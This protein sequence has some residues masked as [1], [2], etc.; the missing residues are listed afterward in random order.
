MTIIRQPLRR[1]GIKW[2]GE[3]LAEVQAY[4]AP[5]SPLYQFLPTLEQYLGMA[6]PRHSLSILVR[7]PESEAKYPNIGP[8]YKLATVMP[9]DW[10]VRNRGEGAGFVVLRAAEF[11]EEWQ[12]YAPVPG[13]GAPLR[14]ADAP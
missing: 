1:D 10:I 8:Q 7:D 3:N 14:G 9:N 4:M 12:E 6:R 2:T 13:V 5:D 11:A